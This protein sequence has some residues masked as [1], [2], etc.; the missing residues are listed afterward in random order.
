MS[1]TTCGQRRNPRRWKSVELCERTRRGEVSAIHARRRTPPALRFLPR[2][3]KK[4]QTLAIYFS[5]TI[6]QRPWGDE[7]SKKDRCS[8]KKKLPTDYAAA[9]FAREHRARVVRRRRLEG[10]RQ[11]RQPNVRT[12]GKERMG[13]VSEGHSPQARFAASR[14]TVTS[15]APPCTLRHPPRPASRDSTPASFSFFVFSLVVASPL[16]RFHLCD[17]PTRLSHGTPAG[18]EFAAYPPHQR[19][20]QLASC[21][22]H[23]GDRVASTWS[24]REGWL[25]SKVLVMNF[26]RLQTFFRLG[27]FSK[28]KCEG[29]KSQQRSANN[30]DHLSPMRFSNKNG[31]HKKGHR[32]VPSWRSAEG[33]RRVEI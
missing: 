22:P 29:K 23:S 1:S 18:F 32:E 13:A 4:K 33:K 30:A 9:P 19:T 26:H 8:E 25:Q 27:S 24:E 3:A 16:C 21:G 6:Y 5:T 11:R 10:E 14:T 28:K 2:P 12:G 17:T 7:C 20:T 31:R 15:S